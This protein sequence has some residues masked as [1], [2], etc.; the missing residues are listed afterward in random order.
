MGN[1]CLLQIS[2]GSR[3][4]SFSQHPSSARPHLRPSSWVTQVIPNNPL[5]WVYLKGSEE[6]PQDTEKAIIKRT[7]L[8]NLIK[9]LL[10][11]G[12]E[13]VRPEGRDYFRCLCQQLRSQS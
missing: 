12:R 8:G 9:L 1:R 2:K 3:A 7:A 11:P 4:P 6:R 13:E 5:L 10:G